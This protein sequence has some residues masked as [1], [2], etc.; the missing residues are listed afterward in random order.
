MKYTD[1]VDIF[2]GC[3][4]TNLPEPEGIAATWYPIKAISGNTNPAAC[5]PFGKYSVG[6]YSS[7]YSSGYWINSVNTDPR[8]NLL[9]DHL[10]LKGF[11]HFHHSGTGY[12]GLFYNYAVT[13][14]YYGEKQEFYEI[15]DEGGRPG[16]YA[17]TLDETDIRC[18][19]TV[20]PHAGYHRYSFSRPEGKISIDFTNDGLYNHPQFRG[21]AQDVTVSTRDS[22]TLLAAATL[23][24]VRMY[25]T[26]VF[27]GDGALDENNVFCLNNPGTV[28]VKMSIS[29]ESEE[30]ALADASKAV[31]TFDEAV[32]AADQLWETALG[33]IQVECEDKIELALFYSNLYHSLVKPND[34]NGGGFLWKGAPFVVD[35]ST[36]WDI[37]KT[38]LPL[39]F[40]LFPEVSSHIVDSLQTLGNTTGHLPV[41][42]LLSSSLDVESGQAR[43]LMEY[44]FYDAWKRGV[45]ADWEKVLDAIETDIANNDYGLFEETGFAHRYTF[46]LDMA[47]ISNGLAEMAE[48]YGRTVLAARFRSNT[49]KWK[50]TFDPA[51]GLMVET[52]DYYEGNN[53]NYSFRPLVHHDERIALCGGK[54]NYVNLLDRFFGYTHPEDTS[55][56]FEGFNNETDMETPYAYHYAGRLDRLCEILDLADKYIFREKDGGTGRGGIPGNNDSGGLSGCYIWNCLGMFPVTGQD[57]ML[58]S[59][60]KFDKVTLVL[61]NG[62]TLIIERNGSGACPRTVSLNGKDLPD[63]RISA[64]DFM[65]GGKIV[66]TY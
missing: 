15:R 39:I 28:I 51:T 8:L 53:W 48:A 57:L 64:Q 63:F 14:P 29:V 13:T 16:Y 4:G 44:A 32:S 3:G 59:R 11:S 65:I 60:P 38:Q 62:N 27:E 54:E 66:F 10:K 46:T 45:Q 19:L 30:D 40:S 12:I 7:G 31:C 35:F 55:A 20:S 52:P 23:Q 50:S 6:P 22:R 9:M 24:G 25:F 37:Y 43:M 47:E 58:L 26:A 5:L 36:M 21:V 49:D 61:A 18:E 33:R 17:V 2:H 56:R 41:S 34:W 42:F 1:Y